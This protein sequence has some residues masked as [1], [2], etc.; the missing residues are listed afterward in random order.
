MISLS[1]SELG[2]VLGS[3]ELIE[4]EAP[5][6]STEET[7]VVSDSRN[8]VPGSIFFALKGEHGHGHDFAAQAV[9]LGASLVVAEAPLE[10][11]V[12]V[13]VVPD[14]LEALSRLARFVVEKV[15]GLGRLS[16][17]AVTGSNGKTTTKNM[18]RTVLSKHGNVVSPQG[19][20]NNQVG[21]PL[22]LL[23]VRPDTDFLVVE[24]GASGIGQ[25]AKLV[26]IVMPDVAIVLKVGLAHVGEFGGI[27][28]TER[29][30]SEIVAS[31][32]RSATAILNA[33]D[34]RVMNMA[35][36]T[37]ARISTFGFS[38]GAD[39]KAENLSASFEGTDFD[40]VTGE[41]RL[42]SSLRILGEHMVM[43]ALA[44]VAATTALGI[45][46]V[47]ALAALSEMNLA[48]RWRM[49][50]LEGPNGS[51]IINDAYNAS[52]DSMA[53]AL[54]TL[55]ELTRGKARSFAVLG[56]M[57]ELGDFSFEE[58][59]R[60]GRLAVR[61]NIDQL[62]V[63]GLGAKPIHVAAGL[64]GSWNGESIFVETP[65]EAY[66]QLRGE[67]LPGDVVLVKSSNSSGLRHLGDQL[68]EVR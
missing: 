47:V 25:I 22:S 2:D 29:A 20:F 62:I 35:G 53:A 38:S 13:A 37:V 55:A 3:I 45:E 36:K 68:A 46:P 57:A 9:D 60:L 11:S 39:F 32:P 30:K 50:I 24:M 56:E 21:T 12:P 15:R 59:D 51:V 34:P 16:V 44:T 14:S 49:Q 27:E 17:V 42:R 31:L 18:L 66:D 4:G 7:L 63:V 48:E 61:L 6:S 33:D 23:G 26:S 58:H 28:A 41:L 65:R 5:F 10:L 64:E 52:P 19:S 40:F 8:A 54:K 67:L 1:L 43:N